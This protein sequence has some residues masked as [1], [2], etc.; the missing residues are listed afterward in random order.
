MPIAIDDGVPVWARDIDRLLMIGEDTLQHAR[1]VCL[2]ARQTR[3]TSSL[4][5][6]QS[7]RER[8]H[9]RMAT[10]LDA[11]NTALEDTSHAL[12]VVLAELESAVD[13]LRTSEL[14]NYALTGQL[15]AAIAQLNELDPL[16][17]ANEA[18]VAY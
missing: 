15:E 18:I 3:H 1:K 4:I 12:R 7:R 8:E 5:R 14:T 17:A 2:A 13:R 16:D 10:V 6:R 11:T 9:R